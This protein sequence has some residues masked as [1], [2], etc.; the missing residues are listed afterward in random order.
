MLESAGH[1][2]GQH[3]FSLIIGKRG[4]HEPAD[5]RSSNL[6]TESFVEHSREVEVERLIGQIDQAGSRHGAAVDY[7]LEIVG[8]SQAILHIEVSR[9]LD[10]ISKAFGRAKAIA[11]EIF[12][13]R[14]TH[15]ADQ[16]SSVCRW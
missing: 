10:E 15:A 8:L 11:H 16:G 12:P 1:D 3:E 6:L 4:V 13:L 9:E 7:G 14:P 2:H 5:L